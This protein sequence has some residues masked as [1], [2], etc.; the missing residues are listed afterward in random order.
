MKSIDELIADLAKDD[1]T[2]Y[3]ATLALGRMRDSNAVEPLFVALKHPN[4]AVREGGAVAPGQIRDV[5]AIQP[6]I[7]PLGDPGDPSDDYNEWNLAVQAANALISFGETA[8]DPVVQAI[9]HPEAV[10]RYRAIYILTEL[11]AVQATDS[12]LAALRD[13]DP[14]VRWMAADALGQLGDLRI[15]P[16]LERVAREDRGKFWKLAVADAARTPRRRIRLRTH[17]ASW[18]ERLAAK[19]R[20]LTGRE[21]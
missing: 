18:H 4:P 15:V 3:D 7:A 13:G 19:L 17:T 9:Q 12:V 2:A 6:L 8:I 14:G 1:A 21:V 11:H 20:R 10:V 16:E 5:R